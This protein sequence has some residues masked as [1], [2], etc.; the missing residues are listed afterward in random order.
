M[1]I[2]F[3]KL[4]R[5]SYIGQFESLVNKFRKK[6]Q[7]SNI[8]SIFRVMTAWNCETAIRET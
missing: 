2:H 6:F 1:E 3:W 7:L 4:F 5:E 8:L